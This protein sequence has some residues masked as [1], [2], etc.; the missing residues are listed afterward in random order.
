MRPFFNLSGFLHEWIL[1]S[2][3]LFIIL[4]Q[5]FQIGVI[6]KACMSVN[7]SST[8][9]SLLKEKRGKKTRKKQPRSLSI[10]RLLQILLFH[11]NECVCMA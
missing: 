4:Y 1:Q 7:L 10:W 6:N 3:L 9:T 8:D 5:N 2:E 11:F